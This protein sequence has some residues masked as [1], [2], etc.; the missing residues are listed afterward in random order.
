MNTKYF[1]SPLPPSTPIKNRNLDLGVSI[2]R[3]IDTRDVYDI[4]CTIYNILYNISL[5][6]IASICVIILVIITNQYLIAR[7]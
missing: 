2:L 7:K 1:L 6:N 5:Y 3:I 4:L